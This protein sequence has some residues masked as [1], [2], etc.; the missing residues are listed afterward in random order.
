MGHI[1]PLRAQFDAFKNLSR[2]HPIEMLNLVQF[3]DQANYPADHELAKAGLTGAEAYGLYGT[4]T[5]PVLE[6]VG[7]SVLWR[8]TFETALIGPISMVD[9]TIPY[10]IANNDLTFSRIDPA[11]NPSRTR[12]CKILRGSP[13]LICQI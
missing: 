11:A 6:R 4:H 1:D 9:I 8:G 13:G 7:G 2:D 12:N 5:R 10:S 3:R